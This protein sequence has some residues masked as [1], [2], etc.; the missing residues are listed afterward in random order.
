MNPEPRPVAATCYVTEA[1]NS[2]CKTCAV[3]R[4]KPGPDAATAEWTDA[5]A[6]LGAA[7]VRSL[8]LSGGEPLLRPDLADLV[9]AARAAGIASVEVASNGLLV[10]GDRL[11]ELTASGLA[12]LHLSVDGLDGVH[13]CIR[14]IPGSFAAV[15]RALDLAL[16]R[17]L[18]VTLNT[19]LLAENLHQ[20]GEVLALAREHGTAWNPNM[21]NNTQ[22]SFAGVDTARL[23]P[24]DRGAIAA[25]TATLERELPGLRSG[26]APR[27]LPHLAQMLTTGEVPQFPCNLGSWLV[28]VYADLSVSPGCSAIKPASSLRQESLADIL[29]GPR[30]RAKVRQMAMRAC[31]GCTCCIWYNLDQAGSAPAMGETAS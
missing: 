30:Y 22:R 11:D 8:C 28:Y 14:G 18:A 19:N 3:W 21:L 29:A 1:C 24:K 20:V 16:A 12:G 31:P 9:Q 17:G 27:H 15:H 2:R 6:Q 10:T 25:L 23:L 4:G 26:L 13:D 5:L 7:G